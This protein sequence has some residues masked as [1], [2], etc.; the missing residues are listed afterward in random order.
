MIKFRWC[1]RE[2]D[3]NIYLYDEDKNLYYH[4]QFDNWYFLD[5]KTFHLY[6]EI[7]DYVIVKEDFK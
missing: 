7:G 2:V 5:N 6:V 4:P 1:D 3:H